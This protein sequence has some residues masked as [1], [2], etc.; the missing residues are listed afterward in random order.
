M[1]FAAAIRGMAGNKH[2]I[3]RT[4]LLAF[5][6]RGSKKSFRLFEVSSRRGK[7]DYAEKDLIEVYNKRF[8]DTGKRFEDI[9]KR[10][11]DTVKHI[12]GVFNA[13]TK[14][15]DDTVAKIMNSDR[16]LFGLLGVFVANWYYIGNK[17]Q[18]F[19]DKLENQSKSFDDN[20][21]SFDDNLKNQSKSFDNKLEQLSKHFDDKLEQQS[22]T[23][24]KMIKKMQTTKEDSSVA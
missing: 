14:R 9:G 6:S 22:K 12:D 16:L 13:M 20:L 17:L 5:G 21:K 1:S 2:G 19:D 15:I 4:T 24:G 10:F 23:L 3:V 7:A 8:E 11:E 18:G